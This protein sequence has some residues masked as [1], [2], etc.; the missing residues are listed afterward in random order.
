[1]NCES[2]SLGV[3][4]HTAGSATCKGY[5]MRI[6]DLA[7]ATFVCGALGFLTYSFPVLGQALVIGLLAL[8]WLLYAQ[9]AIQS[10]RRSR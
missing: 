1:M 7:K 6:L 8:L 5:A 10:L 4:F 3:G 2:A 9:Q